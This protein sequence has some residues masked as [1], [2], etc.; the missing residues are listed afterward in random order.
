MYVNLVNYQELEDDLYKFRE[1]KIYNT[2]LQKMWYSL[3]CH[4][5]KAYIGTVLG[6]LFVCTVSFIHHFPED[7][8]VIMNLLIWL[9]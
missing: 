6:H 7:K 5:I 1:F 9:P 8:Y 4:I 2:I 3:H